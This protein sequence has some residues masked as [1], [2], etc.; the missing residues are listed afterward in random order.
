MNNSYGVYWEGLEEELKKIL[1]DKEIFMWINRLSFKN[2]DTHKN[3]LLLS[4]PSNFIKDN[5]TKNYL[6]KMNSILCN[7]SGLDTC[8]IELIV[9]KNE[10]VINQPILTDNKTTEKKIYSEPIIENK[11]KTETNSEKKELSIKNPTDKVEIDDNYS[12]ESFIIGSSNEFAAHAARTV[13]ENPGTSYNPY[14]IWGES[15]LGKTHLLKSIMKFVKENMPDK[16][17]KYVTSEE[18]TNDFVLSIRNNNPEIFRAKYRPLDVLL[19]DDVQFFANK[20]GVQGEFFNTFETLFE[21]R[22][23]MV[24]SCDQPISKVKKMEDRIKGRFA[25]GLTVDL[26]PPDYELK[27]AILNNMADNYGLNFEKD[28]MD[29]ICTNI[30]GNIR[31]LKGSFKDLHA[32]S[33]I[34]NIKTITIKIALDRLKEKITNNMFS[35]QVSVDKIIQ[36]VGEYYDITTIDLIGS[37]RTKSIAHARQMAMYLSRKNTRLSTTQIGAYFGNKEHGT[38]MHATKKIEDLINKDDKIKGEIINLSNRIK[39][40]E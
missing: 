1:T 35:T 19:I 20:E 3:I 38:V 10:T 36:I 9:E 7:I 24:F 2:F 4:A 39:A 13:A 28:A 6:S 31:E 12:F 17:V 22:K 40:S 15:G 32:Y 34:M 16:K 14:F 33:S 23:Q 18:F 5:V 30:H 11:I 25:M 8:S 27:M 26:R 37:K 21:N 29:Y